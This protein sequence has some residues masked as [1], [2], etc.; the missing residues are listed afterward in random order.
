MARWLIPTL[1]YVVMV[2][3]LG[4]TSKLALRS[5][6]WQAVIVATVAIY[7]VATVVF[8]ALGQIRFGSSGTNIFWAF[9]SGVLAVGSLILLYVALN[10][11]EA[12]KV[13]PV[14]AAYP[15]VTLVL[16]AIFLSEAL[17]FGRA[18]GA[19]L[20]I[21]GVVVLTTVK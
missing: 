1:G 21:G 16:A 6:S 8:A 5:V 15:A 7:L 4:V 18:A 10:T 12:G 3:A 14:S 13:V 9:A 20:V 17:T 2:G 19:L 11:G